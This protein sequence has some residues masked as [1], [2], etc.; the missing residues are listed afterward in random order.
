MGKC[1][2]VIESLIP[3]EKLSLRTD[4]GMGIRWDKIPYCLRTMM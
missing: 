3:I 2:Q 4:V 1:V